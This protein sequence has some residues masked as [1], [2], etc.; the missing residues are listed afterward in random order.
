MKNTISFSVLGTI[1]FTAIRLYLGYDWIEAGFNKLAGNSFNAAGFIKGALSKTTG[2]HPDVQ[3]WW[4]HFLQHFAL[5][6]I[7]IFN[8]L[9]PW[10]EFLVGLSLIF[11][12]FTRFGVLMGIVMNFSYMFSGSISTNPEMLLLGFII[13]I[14]ST[15]TT[16]FG[17]DYWII[18]K[19]RSAF[20][21]IKLKGILAHQ[22]E[23]T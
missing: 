18:P 23:S 1:I 5:P 17:L 22:S 2:V 19:T 20:A 4:A 13:F 11:G 7:E 15:K 3:S 10:G 9:V 12:I 16:Q 14:Y 21:L 8:T 6:H